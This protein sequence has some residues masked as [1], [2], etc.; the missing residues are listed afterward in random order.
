MS[1]ETRCDKCQELIDDRVWKLNLE[2]SRALQ[3]Q[4]FGMEHYDLC[5]ACKNK[6]FHTETC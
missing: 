3:L 4:G 6:W 1:V 2:P 5:A